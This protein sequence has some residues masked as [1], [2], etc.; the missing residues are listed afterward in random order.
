[1][2]STPKPQNLFLIT[3]E[4][5]R[6]KK[7]P[8]VINLAYLGQD[9]HPPQVIRKYL[10]VPKTVPFVRIDVKFKVSHSCLARLLK[11]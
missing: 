4:E 11:D 10:R 5:K 9:S 6:E 8:E 7:D 3:K 2:Q 1:M